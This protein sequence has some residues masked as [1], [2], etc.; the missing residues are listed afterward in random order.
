MLVRTAKM[1]IHTIGGNSSRKTQ[2]CMD[3]LVLIGVAKDEISSIRVML[4]K[5]AAS[6]VSDLGGNSMDFKNHGPKLGP[7]VR[8]IL[9]PIF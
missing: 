4:N 1:I 2:T 3:R 8:P 5:V 6:L 7:K 9:G